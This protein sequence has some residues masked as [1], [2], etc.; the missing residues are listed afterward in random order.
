M[1]KHLYTLAAA[2]TLIT[3]VGCA[4]NSLEEKPNDSDFPLQLLMDAREGA[5]LPDAEDYS[6]E[7][8]FADYLPDAEL[9]KNSITID[10]TITDLEDDMVDHIGIDKIVYEVEADDCVY[11]REIPFTSNNDGLSGTITLAVDEDLKSVPTSFEVILTLPGADET[12]GSFTFELS[13]LKSTDRVILGSPNVFEYEVLDNDAAGEWELEFSNE[14]EFEAFKSI[15]GPLSA[16]LQTISFEDITGKVKAEFEFEEMKFEIEL[17][18]EEEVTTCENGESETETENKVIEIEAEYEAEDGELT[19]EGSHVIVNDDG[20]EEAELD[21]I[22]DSEYEINEA[23]ETITIHF[24]KVVDED[25]F[26]EGD[27]LFN[28]GD[29]ISF[30]FK[31]D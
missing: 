27:E 10:Y 8:K 1:K 17:A 5:A 4:D 26:K 29:G 24:L 15:F 23:E 11:E 7:V 28:N 30:T 9:P 3:F 13:N 20:I 16:D 18:E 22:I 6:I 21:F 2:V 31:K 12:K 19:L 14:E 25:H